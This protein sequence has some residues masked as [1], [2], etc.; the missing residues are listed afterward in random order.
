MSLE[1]KVAKRN[2]HSSQYALSSLNVSHVFVLTLY[3]VDVPSN[4]Q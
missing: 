4:Y 3:Y 1:C 2:L